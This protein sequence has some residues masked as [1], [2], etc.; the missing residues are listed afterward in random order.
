MDLAHL[1][2]RLERPA[3]G[4]GLLEHHVAQPALDIVEPAQGDGGRG[5]THQGVDLPLEPAVVQRQ[6]ADVLHD[7]P[8][9]VQQATQ[10]APAKSPGPTTLTRAHWPG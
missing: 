4:L 3:L 6:L 5:G 1:F 10:T 7:Q 8:Q 2:L 9:Q